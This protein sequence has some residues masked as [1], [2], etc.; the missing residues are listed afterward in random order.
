[1]EAPSADLAKR[2]LGIALIDAGLERRTGKLIVSGYRMLTEV[3]ARP[4][5]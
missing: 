4:A 3:Q 5:R 2:N 1:M